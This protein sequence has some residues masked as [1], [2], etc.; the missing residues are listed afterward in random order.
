MNSVHIN[1]PVNRNIFVLL[2]TREDLKRF[3]FV[4]PT[5]AGF[6]SKFISI[7]LTFPLEY[8]ATLKQA[9]LQQG[10]KS[11]TNGLGYTLY[12]E[13]LYSAC[14]WTIQDNL[15]IRT[16]RLV[17]SDR[18]AYITSSFISSIISATISYPFDLF[19]T[20]KISHPEKFIQSN[21]L[22]VTLEIF[23]EKGSTAVWAGKKISFRFGSKT[24]Q[25][26]HREPDLFHSVHKSSTISHASYL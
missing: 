21:P 13:L 20:W 23:K 22:R 12:R 25:S 24:R 19:K 8:Q 1:N 18:K 15:Y 17:D 7:S 2:S 9:D 16:R 10:K 3:Q 5:I 4:S 6:S 26:W 11:L 14:F